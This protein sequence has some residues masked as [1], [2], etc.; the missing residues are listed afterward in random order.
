MPENPPELSYD[1]DRSIGFGVP[2][3][4]SRE[5]WR[6]LSSGLYYVLLQGVG[7]EKQ[8]LLAILAKIV[9]TKVSREVGFG[10]LDL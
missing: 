7:M 10:E 1:R 2:W 6:S 4:S 9:S 8:G 3:R 5:L